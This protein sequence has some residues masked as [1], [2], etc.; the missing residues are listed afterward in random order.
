MS[1]AAPRNARRKT[2]FKPLQRPCLTPRPS[3]PR[4]QFSLIETPKSCP[5]AD[6]INPGASE[7]FGAARHEM[8]F[9]FG[10]YFNM[11]CIKTTLAAPPAFLS[12]LPPTSLNQVRNYEYPIDKRLIC[13]KSS[14][15]E[16][17]RFHARK[18]ASLEKHCFLRV[19]LPLCCFSPEALVLTG[20]ALSLQ[21]R[22]ASPQRRP[23]FHTVTFRFSRITFLPCI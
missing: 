18:G 9:Q 2:P 15:D 3:A 20:N 19:A 17:P 13:C 14:R 16:S 5:P 4:A 23:C 21:K 8:S 10:R 12:S 6:I 1:F 7:G 22:S 11:D